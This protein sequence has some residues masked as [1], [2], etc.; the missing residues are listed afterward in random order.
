MLHPARSNP[1]I[2]GYMALKQT[3]RCLFKSERERKT[4]KM[5]KPKLI[6][7]RTAPEWFRGRETTLPEPELMIRQLPGRAYENSLGASGNCWMSDSG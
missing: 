6:S 3:L 4:L 5:F 1:L 2:A 7:K